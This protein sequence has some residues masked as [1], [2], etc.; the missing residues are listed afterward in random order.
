ML[1]KLFNRNK[2]KE[3]PEERIEIVPVPALVAVLLNKERE[4]GS[5]LTEDE[6]IEIRDNAACIAMPITVIPKLEEERGYA[7]ID[8]ELAWE[9][10]QSVRVQFFNNENL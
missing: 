3:E 5:P 2:K 1:G 7:D 8:P 4:K 9:E 6:V 10:W